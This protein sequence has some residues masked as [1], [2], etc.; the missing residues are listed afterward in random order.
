IAKKDLWDTSGHSSFYMENMFPLEI[1]EQDYILKPM[2]CPFHMLIYKSQLR[3][4][5]E[6]PVRL[7]ELGT[8]YRYE[9]SGVMHGLSRVRG[10]TQ[11]DAHLYCRPDQLIDEIK[12]I[13]RFI[14]DT[15][16]LF[17]MT[18]DVEL[19]TRPEKYVGELELW[20]K[21][22]AGLKEAL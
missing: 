13:I 6:L 16:K 22:E 1:E 18:F 4:Y 17:G 11:D 7:A 3:S 14:D 20:D 9:K 21:A 12:S 19:S 2:N 10:F 8:V 15:L 5:R